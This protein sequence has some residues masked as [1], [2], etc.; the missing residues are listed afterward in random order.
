L[1]EDPTMY[2]SL[3]HILLKELVESVKE[4]NVARLRN[5]VTRHNQSTKIDRIQ[6]VLLNKIRVKIEQESTDNILKDT[7]DFL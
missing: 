6:T 2:D 3:E 1:N 7:E 5:A 4:K